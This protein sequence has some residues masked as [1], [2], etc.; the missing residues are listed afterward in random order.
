[1]VEGLEAFLH[2]F[3]GQAGKYTIIGGTACDY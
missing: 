1:M 2:H 3:A